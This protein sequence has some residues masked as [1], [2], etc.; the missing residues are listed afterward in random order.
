MQQKGK[1]KYPAGEIFKK[2]ALLA[3]LC[4]QKWRVLLF[5]VVNGSTTL[6]PLRFSRTSDRS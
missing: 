3:L 2:L 1:Q 4:R 5:Q 6:P